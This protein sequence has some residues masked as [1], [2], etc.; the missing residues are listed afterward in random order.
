[1]EGISCGQLEV[2]EN[3]DDPDGR[4][5]YIAYV[6]IHSRSTKPAKDPLI[7]F[8][9]G[10]GGNTL[11]R[12]RLRNWMNSSV[13]DKRDIILFDQRG[14]GYSSALEEMGAELFDVM[15]EN[16]SEE[17][18]QKG[19]SK[20]IANTKRKSLEKG[21]RL[22]F[23][24]SFQNARDVGQL[25]DHL[26][27]D[28]YNLYGV[29]YGTRLA[30]VVQE[31]FPDQI[32]SVTLNS[33]NPLV[34]DFLVDRIHSYS[35][36]L[37][38]IF[39]YCESSSS[40]A[41]EYPNLKQ[42]YLQAIESLKENPMK[43]TVK[44]KPFYVNAQDALYFLR[45]RLYANDARTAVPRLIQEY[46]KGKGEFI[47]QIITQESN[48]FANS[49]NFA[50]WISVENQEMYDPKY[51]TTAVDKVYSELELLPA[52]LGFFHSIYFGSKD[53][54]QTIL[55]KEEKSFDKSPVPTVITVNHFDPVTPPE[56]GHIMMESLEKGQ[57]YILDEG[58]H[59]GGNSA[60]RTRLMIDF[61][62]N[63]NRSLDTSCLNIYHS[64]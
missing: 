43:L 15:A 17:G 51:T 33:P 21:V 48:F 42:D 20:V 7:F 63:P 55:T 8:S 52:K 44:G 5:I 24:N 30:R 11:S 22:E 62:D 41:S 26:G 61:M 2:P 36:A 35:L 34:G 6:V 4:K 56:F 39:E 23:Y 45:R 13:R 49:Y 31:I 27:Y 38:R 28:S 57:L 59:G 9:G 37:S 10:P 1:M 3:H 54:A 25:M 12:G 18:E 14:I 46:K 47:T 40:C 29:S 16:L 53:W 19:V 58:G 32:R 64:N 50:M 60:C